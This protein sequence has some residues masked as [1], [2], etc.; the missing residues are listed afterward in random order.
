MSLDFR[1]FET[2]VTQRRHGPKIEAKFWIFF[3]QSVK[4]NL[5]KLQIV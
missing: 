1:H 5:I 4:I 3:V 2:K